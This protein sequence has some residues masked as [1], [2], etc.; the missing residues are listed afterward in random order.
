[1]KKFNTSFTGYSKNEVNSFVNEVAKE[2]EGMLKNLKSKDLEIQNLN[3][4]L[5]KYKNIENTLNR[6]LLVAEDAST[7]IKRAAHD[8]S[9]GLIEDARRNA[10]KIVN[11]ALLRA[12]QVEFEAKTLKS[13]V[14]SFKRR[15]RAA[16]EEQIN[17]LE[18]IDERM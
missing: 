3:K 17:S 18:D 2:Y 7:N 16:L 10:S 15:F 1:M 9:K 8:E 12:E 13:R 6:A 14:N 11:D 5:E 4:E